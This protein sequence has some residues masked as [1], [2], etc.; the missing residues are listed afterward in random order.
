M[1]FEIDLNP[2]EEAALDRAWAKVGDPDAPPP[3]KDEESPEVPLTLQADPIPL[4]LDDEGGVRVGETRVLLELVIE[5]HRDGAIPE[6][7]V[8]W[9]DSLRLADVYAVI[10][11]YLKHKAEVE[12]YLR[13]REKFAAQV[14]RTIEAEQPSRPNFREELLARRARTEQSN[15]SAGE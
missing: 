11:Y 7:I 10:S 9:F 2:E 8:Q 13:R 5:A 15:A 3:P 12:E 6:T 1:P 4:R 14:R